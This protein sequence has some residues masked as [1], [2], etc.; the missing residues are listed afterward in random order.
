LFFEH[1]NYDKDKYQNIPMM[2]SQC[3]I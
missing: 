3:T 1:L 2:A